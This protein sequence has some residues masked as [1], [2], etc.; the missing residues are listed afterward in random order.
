MKNKIFK[1]DN[2]GKSKAFFLKKGN[3][4][5]KNYILDLKKKTLQSKKD[6][7][8][9]LHSNKHSSLHLM[10]NCLVKKKEYLPHKHKNKDEFYYLL[11]GKLK[12][13]FVDKKNKELKYYTISK[14]NN[15]FY[16]NK[17]IIHY[18]IPLTKT[19]TF[20]EARPG[21][22]KKSDTVI[23]KKFKKKNK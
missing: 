9:C 4:L 12:I 2:T 23:Y 22:F 21:P 15:F 3:L 6:N 11:D 13:I 1:V 8:I 14:S 16:L 17:N 10:I 19:C 7:R 18:T 5:K 20:I